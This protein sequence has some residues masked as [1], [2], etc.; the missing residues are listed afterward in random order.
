[1][2]ALLFYYTATAVHEE[3]A[4]RIPNGA[5]LVHFRH[6]KKRTGTSWELAHLDV[7]S[8]FFMNEKE[9]CGGN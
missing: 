1:M 9:K 3:V 4:Q 5:W 2:C 6:A 7:C 8:S